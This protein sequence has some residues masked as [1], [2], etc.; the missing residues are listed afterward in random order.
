MTEDEQPDVAHD[1]LKSRLHAGLT[2]ENAE[3][4]QWP[5]GLPGQGQQPGNSPD[6]VNK[7]LGSVSETPLTSDRT[8]TSSRTQ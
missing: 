2:L 5:V 6:Q 7:Q 1:L 3:L 4:S 8:C